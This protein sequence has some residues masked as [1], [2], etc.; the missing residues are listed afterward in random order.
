MINGQ[1][2]EGAPPCH[3]NVHGSELVA[4]NYHKGTVELFRVKD[5][6]G[7]ERV[8]SVQHEG[9]E[10]HKRQEKP[11]VHFAGR[12]PDAKYVV[13]ADLGTYKLVTYQRENDELLRVDTVKAKPGSG[14]RHIDFH[15]DG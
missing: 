4:G 5:T 2:A 15:P 8:S 13:V 9:N 14:P 12:T 3:L 10:P 7:V 1:L 6:G 11:H